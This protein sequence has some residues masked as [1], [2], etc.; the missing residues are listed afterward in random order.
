MV[1]PKAGK[2]AGGDE[3]VRQEQGAADVGAGI[4]LEDHGDDVGAAGGSAHIEQYCRTHR[5]QQHTEDQFQQG[6]I[7]QGL[8]HGEQ[9]FKQAEESGHGHGDI[10]GADT[11]ALAEHH[12]AQDRAGPG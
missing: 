3:E 2:A 5:G 11:E 6:L 12:S 1:A 9:N 4:L 8:A 10:G 7:G